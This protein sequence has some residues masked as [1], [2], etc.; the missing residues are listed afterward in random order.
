MQSRT[1]RRRL[2]VARGARCICAVLGL[3]ISGMLLL[4]AS[5]ALAQTAGISGKVSNALTHQPI[6]GIEACAFSTTASS[7][8]EEKEEAPGI[9]GCATTGS[10]GEYTISGLN[11]GSYDVVFEAPFK[12]ALNYVPQFYEGKPSF[13]EATTV[14][15]TAGTVKSGVN[16][17]LEPGAEISGVVT[18]AATGAPLEGIL[19]CALGP[20]GGES[21]SARTSCAITGAGGAYALL[22]LRGGSYEVLFF[23]GGRFASQA[24]NGKGTPAEAEPVAVSAGGSI[25]GINA[26]LAPGEGPSAAGSEP[27]GSTT[28]TGL[29]P[30]SGPPHGLGGKPGLSLASRQILLRAHDAGIVKLR[31]IGKARCRGRLTL[32]VRRP[33][34]SHAGV[35]RTVVISR[36][37][38]VSLQPGASVRVRLS[39]NLVG[40]DLLRANRALPDAHLDFTGAAPSGGVRVQARSVI[41][42]RQTRHRG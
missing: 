5:P 8:E 29:L 38:A 6:E 27:G 41:V 35:A 37:V 13:T 26:A 25:S 28:G 40:R 18:E 39:L 22:G 34:G 30:S 1:G 3:S 14:T 11:A 32:T 17:E 31:C 20:Q 42:E 12:S 4:F 7:A 36:P 16:A 9:F 2:G 15:L 21:G 10:G 19:V 24:Y 23:G 33:V